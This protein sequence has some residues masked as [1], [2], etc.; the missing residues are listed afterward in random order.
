M[1]GI[2]RM[3]RIHKR[4]PHKPGAEVRL[5]L[6]HMA[7]SGSFGRIHDRFVQ[8]HRETFVSATACYLWSE[9]LAHEAHVMA[10]HGSD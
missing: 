2:G 9:L 4:V 6:G 7:L 5:L 8:R 10:I 3:R 1:R